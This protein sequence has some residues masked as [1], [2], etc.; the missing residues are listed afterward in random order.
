MGKEILNE[1]DQ[2]SIL[3]KVSNFHVS[4]DKIKTKDAANSIKIAVG[5]LF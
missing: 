5:L 2:M 3:R 1:D 4:V